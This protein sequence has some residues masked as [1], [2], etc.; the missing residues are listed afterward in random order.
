MESNAIVI[1]S[2]SIN[3]KPC[4]SRC[5]YW[6][7]II[8]AAVALPLPS[9]IIGASDVPGAYVRGDE[10]IFPRDVVLQGEENH[11]IKA[12]GWS[13]WVS[14]VDAEGVYHS[15]RS[16]YSAQK[17]ELKAQGLRAELLTGAGDVAGAIRVAHGMRAGMNITSTSS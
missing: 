7:K 8:R 15:H 16:G 13:Y 1:V 3:L 9:A 2:K 4:D 14:W 6:A 11:H 12:R 5:K 10:E 17:T